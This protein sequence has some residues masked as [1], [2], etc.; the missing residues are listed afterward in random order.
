MS[1]G[2]G[3]VSSLPGS[4]P[5]EELAARGRWPAAW[6]AEQM[7]EMC[8]VLLTQIQESLW[9]PLASWFW[10]AVAV[11]VVAFDV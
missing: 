4:H 5:G 2:V 1:R 8:L 10:G 11:F 3:W 9:L 7:P 6:G